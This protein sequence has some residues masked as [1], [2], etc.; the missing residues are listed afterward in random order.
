MIY[1][2]SRHPIGVY[3]FFLSDEYIQS[4]IKHVFALPSFIMVM[5]GGWDFE[6]QKHAS[7]HHEKCFTWLCGEN[8][9]LLKQ[10]PA[11]V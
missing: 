10:I 2:P 8:K 11:F 7:I 5:N 9:G 4:Y 6:A 1:S 3:D